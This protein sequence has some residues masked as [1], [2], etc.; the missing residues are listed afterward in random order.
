LLAVGAGTAL[1]LSF[2]IHSDGVQIVHDSC[3]FSPIA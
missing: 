3:D 1:A 2:S